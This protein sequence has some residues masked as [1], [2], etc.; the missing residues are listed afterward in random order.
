MQTKAPIQEV[1]VMLSEKFKRS[2]LIR[3]RTEEKLAKQKEK[4]EQTTDRISELSKQPDLFAIVTE[5]EKEQEKKAVEVIEPLFVP[6]G[7]KE[8]SS[9]SPKK[10]SPTEMKNLDAIT[11]AKYLAYAEPSPEIQTKITLSELRARKLLEEDR[12]RVHQLLLE[13][14]NK[15][16]L[17][18]RA[19]EDPEKRKVGIELANL[20]KQRLAQKKQSLKKAR[21]CLFDVGRRFTVPYRR[22]KNFCRRN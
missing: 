15:F 1:P 8:S 18:H 12:R 9:F 16:D 13:A 20:A 2:M 7:L 4:S 22:T 5:Q 3:K 14:K 11:R 21:V 6:F 17:L 19:V 10:M